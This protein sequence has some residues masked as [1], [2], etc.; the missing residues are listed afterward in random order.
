MQNFFAEGCGRIAPG[1]FGGV[2]GINRGVH[3]LCLRHEDPGKR[4]LIGRV[5]DLGHCGGRDFDGFAAN[6]GS[7][8]HG[9]PSSPGADALSVRWSECGRTARVYR[10]IVRF[11]FVW[12][13]RF[14]SGNVKPSRQRITTIPHSVS[15]QLTPAD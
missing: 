8:E 4:L 5:E 11:T 6:V 14:C 12:I 1:C 3:V 13:L 15:W 7:G 9:V 10:A 2:G